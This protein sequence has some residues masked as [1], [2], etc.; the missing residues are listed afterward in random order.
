MFAGFAC[1]FQLQRRS[2]GSRLQDRSSTRLDRAQARSPAADPALAT[3]TV[4][5]HHPSSPEMHEL[6]PPDNL[7]GYWS[8]EPSATRRSLQQASI[9]IRFLE[10]R[11]ERHLGVLP[12][13]AAAAA[14]SMEAWTQHPQGPQGISAGQVSLLQSE[15]H[16][17]HLLYR[18]GAPIHP[19]QAQRQLQHQAQHQAQEEGRQIRDHT[20][21]Q[22]RSPDFRTVDAASA[23][24][25]ALSEKGPGTTASGSSSAATASSD[26]QRWRRRHGLLISWT[27]TR[28]RT[29]IWM[30]CCCFLLL[31]SHGF[32]ACSYKTKTQKKFKRVKT[33]RQKKGLGGCSI[34]GLGIV[35]CLVSFLVSCFASLFLCGLV[36]CCIVFVF[37][38]L[39]NW[40]GQHSRGRRD[41]WWCSIAPPLVSITLPL[42]PPCGSY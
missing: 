18:L 10:E 16:A 28:P 36:R 19:P 31:V 13:D 17:V 4:K 32:S 14:F 41:G 6:Y 15:R 3:R 40:P 1:C 23:L 24:R 34:V 27:R 9:E 8:P 39:L 21:R 29:R 22:E 30:C 33:W 25:R 35:S 37:S 26:G 5:G 2:P 7:S 11:L 20:G 12:V 38:F 42:P